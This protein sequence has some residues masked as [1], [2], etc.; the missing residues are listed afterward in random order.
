MRL[1]KVVRDILRRLAILEN[2]K[3]GPGVEVTRRP[4]GVVIGVNAQKVS[5]RRPGGCSG[6]TL[7]VLDKN[8]PGTKWDRDVDR[9]PVSWDGNYVTWNKDDDKKLLMHQRIVEFDRC[10]NLKSISEEFTAEI[11]TAVPCVCDGGEGE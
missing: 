8:V 7:L 9:R 2:I 6:G 4:G 10:G 3:G 1:D 11:D 5:A